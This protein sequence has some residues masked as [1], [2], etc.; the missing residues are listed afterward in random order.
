MNGFFFPTIFA[1]SFPP[2][3]VGWVTLDYYS[4]QHAN[5]F[6]MR[7]ETLKSK[8]QKLSSIVSKLKTGKLTT[9]GLVVPGAQPPLTSLL[10]SASEEQR[11]RRRRG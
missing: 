4:T 11:R 1:T 5:K 8:L 2:F 9:Q 7:P 6:I 3:T 10:P